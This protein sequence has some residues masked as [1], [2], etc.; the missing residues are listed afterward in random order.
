MIFINYTYTIPYIDTYKSFMKRT[1]LLK[2][3]TVKFWKIKNAYMNSSFKSW[4]WKFIQ[5]F[6]NK[7]FTKFYL[8]VIS[9][10]CYYRLNVCVLPKFLCWNLI[11]NVTVFRGRNFGRWLSHE[12]GVFMNGISAFIKDT[13][14]SSLAPSAMWGCREK[15]VVYESGIRP[16]PDTRSAGT[17][18]LDFLVSKTVRNKFVL[19]CLVNGILL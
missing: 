17:L 12:S 13:P 8:S 4:V 6:I 16:S 3:S 2:Y 9:K 18:I 14:G 1:N 15:A 19:Y 7:G 11:P 5:N 10:T